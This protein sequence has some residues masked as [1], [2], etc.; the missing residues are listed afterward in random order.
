M[1]VF[2][3]KKNNIIENNRQLALLKKYY[4]VDEANRIVTIKIN[5]DKSS[6][7]LNTNVGN[8]DN[9]II[10]DDALENIN[11]IIQTIPVYFKV[12]FDFDIEDYEGYD[13]KNIIQSFNDT[14]ELNQY[15]SR[16]GRQRKYLIAATLVLVGV[17]LLCFMVIGKNKLWFGEGIKAEVIAEI[18]NIAAWVFVW[19]AVSMLFLEK[20]KQKIFALRIRTRVSEIIMVDNKTKKVIAK[21]SSQ[22]I[23]GKWDNE[24]SL[25]RLGK[26][27]TLIS[28]MILIFTSVYTFY[29]IFEYISN[30]SGFSLALFLIIKVIS[31]IVYLLAG[32]AGLMSYLGKKSKISKILVFYA[33]ILFINLLITI[34]QFIYSPSFSL[35]FSLV[36]FLIFNVLYIFGY[37][38][39]CLDY[40]KK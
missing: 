29:D 12:E 6:D 23:F 35:A 30:Y 14:L 15:T 27:A 32:I 8:H 17:I 18:I 16:R 3:I 37:I 31:I 20:S 4:D 34:I 13:P 26:L 9:P 24:G 28:S 40:K 38:V 1:V 22:S 25:R 5:Y 39:D 19:E 7:L 10:R 21:E 2:V 36:G 11:N 33:V